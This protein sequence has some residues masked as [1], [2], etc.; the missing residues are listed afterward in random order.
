MTG[1]LRTALVKFTLAAM[2]LAALALVGYLFYLDRMI[3]TTFEGRRW[4]VPAVVYAQ[5]LELYSGVGLRLADVT[6]ELD[7]LGYRQLANLTNPGT[8]KRTGADLS[9]HLRAFHFMERARASQRIAIGFNERFFQGTLDEI[10]IF[11]RELRSSEVMSL[12]LS[13]RPADDN[14]AVTIPANAGPWD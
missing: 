3:T 13:E 11:N 14:Q 10:K 2:S 1:R 5:P 9:I 7:R 4:S 6:G 8:Y 12:Y